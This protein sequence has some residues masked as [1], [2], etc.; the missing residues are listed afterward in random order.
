M[1]N[2]VVAPESWSEP[3]ARFAQ[4]QVSGGHTRSTVKLRDYHLRR[5]ASRVGKPPFEVSSDDLAAHL[6]SR[7]WSR[8]TKRAVRATLR[9]FYGWAEATERIAKDPSRTLPAVSPNAG[10][11]RPAPDV[12]VEHAIRTASPDV[13]LMI[14]L[15][16]YAGL[17]CCEI[18]KVR[19]E[20]V[21][22]HRDSEGA[23]YS[24]RID[25]K[26]EKIRIVPLP[27][28]VALDLLDRDGI[29][30][31]GQI[32]GHLSAGYVSK[33]ISAALPEG[34][35]AH[36]LRHRFAT[37]AYGGSKNL[38]AVQELLGHASIATT[39]VYTFVDDDELRSAAAWAS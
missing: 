26:G 34:V 31:P 14:R 13:A 16:A 7:G 37:K 38:R 39:Q 8:N 20:H 32:D 5:F 36:M 35:T 24:L 30:F 3:L 6:A 21:G 18:A 27:P 25:G 29:A 4:V 10:K 15:G 28:G 17:R 33:L 2:E 1:R 12:D 23:Y 22:R 11:P 19:S 9:A